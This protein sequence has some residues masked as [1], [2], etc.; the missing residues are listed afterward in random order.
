MA[1]AGINNASVLETSF[2]E[3][4]LTRTSFIRKMWRDLEGET[5]IRENERQQTSGLIANKKLGSQCSCSSVGTESEDVL[6]NTSEAENECPRENQIEIKNVVDDTGNTCV[7]RSPAISVADKERVRQVFREWGSKNSSGRALEVPHKSNCSRIQRLC[8]NDNRVRTVRQWLESNVQQVETGPSVTE[9]QAPKISSQGEREQ[10]GSV[11][12]L[13]RVCARKPVRG[14]QALLDLISRFEMEREKEI[15]G[16]LESQLVSNFAQRNRIQAMLKGRFLCQRSPED[17]KSNSTAANELGLLRQK[18]TVSDL[19]KGFLS[20]V[21]SQ[22]DTSSDNGSK[23]QESQPQDDIIVNEFETICTTSNIEET[24]CHSKIGASSPKYNAASVVETLKRVLE[25]KVKLPSPPSLPPPPPPP[26]SLP[27]PS[28][29]P[30]SLLPASLLPPPPPPPPTGFNKRR[31]QNVTHVVQAPDHIRSISDVTDKRVLTKGKP[32]PSPLPPPPPPPPPPTERFKIREQN[33]NLTSQTSDHIHIRSNVDGPETDGTFDRQ[34]STNAVIFSQQESLA[35]I[36][37]NLASSES[38]EGPHEETREIE[39]HGQYQSDKCEPEVNETIDR[40]SSSQTNTEILSWQEGSVESENN[41]TKTESIVSSDAASVKGPA[42]VDYHS[43]VDEPEVYETF[44]HQNPSEI[45]TVLFAWE[46]GS[47]EAED[48]LNNTASIEC[49]D[50]NSINTQEYEPEANETF[51]HQNHLETDNILSQQQGSVE[52]EERL[53][54]TGSTE[55]LDANSIENEDGW[56]QESHDDWYE[57][58]PLTDVFYTWDDDNSGRPELRE[59]TRRRRVSNLLQSDFRVRLDQLLLSY[60]QRHYQAPESDDFEW[61]LQQDSDQQSIDENADVSEA[62]ESR[63]SSHSLPLTALQH[64]GNEWDIINGLRIDMIL[65]HERMNSMQSTLENCMKMQ[66]ELQRSVKQE[67]SSALSRSSSSG[68]NLQTC[69]LCC[70][71]D[72]SPNGGGHTF[73]CSNCAEKINWSKLKESV[74][75]P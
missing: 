71:S 41:L 51:F 15:K 30:P 53:T 68:D 38:N 49:S 7:Q 34:N 67:V 31:E 45:N 37:E 28:L 52:A 12:D 48:S 27:P 9:E 16:L 50:A 70:D 24:H 14:K 20:R 40:Q 10:D 47:V 18:H 21:D 54:N 42:N 25:T 57:N 63:R 59:L 56:Y 32:S 26:P 5:R 33:V 8:E 62:V 55:S 74:R 65:L 13:T 11:S 3:K 58:L 60:I 2:H 39:A 17:E 36:E 6:I 1:V 4:P 29:P 22:S 43:D 64:S 66:L 61:M 72:S 44:N 19:R 46:E 75:H 69:F 23:S 73:V 35:N